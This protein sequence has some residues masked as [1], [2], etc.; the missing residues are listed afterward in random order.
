[1]EEIHFSSINKSLVTFEKRHENHTTML[2]FLFYHSIIQLTGLYII[3]T[4]NS[5]KK[6]ELKFVCHDEAFFFH[7]FF[8][9]F[10]TVAENLYIVKCEMFFANIS[11]RD[12]SILLKTKK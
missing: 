9:F 3:Y 11:N 5:P 6:L 1:M 12:I 8:L 2:I 7:F 10:Q 4:M